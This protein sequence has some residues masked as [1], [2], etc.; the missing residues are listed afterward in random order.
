MK[1][2]TDGIRGP[3]ATVVTPAVAWALGRALAERLETGAT[4]AVARDSRSSG[5]ALE[6]AVYAGL[7]A[8]GIRVIRLG[9]L[10]TPGLSAL[11]RAQVHRDESGRLSGGWQAGV[12]ITASHNPPEDNGLKLFGELGTKPGRELLDQ[13]GAGIDRWLPAAPSS[14]P[15][16]PRLDSSFRWAVPYFHIFQRA[17]GASEAASGNFR[18]LEGLHIAVDCANGAFS[19]LAADFLELL[20][21]TPTALNTGPG[22]AINQDCGSLHPELLREHL[23]HS[24]ADYGIA[25]DGDGDR[26]ILLLSDGRIL[27][28]DDL[29]WILGQ[30][31]P[32]RSVVVGTVMTNAGLEVALA[33]R[34][35]SLERTPVGDS[36]VAEALSR[37][38][39]ISPEAPFLMT[40]L[41]GEPSGH[42]L[43]SPWIPCADGLLA[44]VRAIL[45]LSDGATL[46]WPRQPQLLRNLRFPHGIPS[47][48]EIQRRLA[49]L[50]AELEAQG[51]RIVVRPSGTEPLVR[52]MVEHPTEAEAALRRLC[53]ALQP[54]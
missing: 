2:G 41:G 25:L 19:A 51:T 5:P 11:L 18:P 53:D 21:A 20:G 1:F 16:L 22:T 24:N 27:D 8:G 46:D 35:L 9:V 47:T 15:P 50:T 36:Y 13:L 48:E 23:L 45:A 43:L 32:A 52:V 37:H 33:H 29:L 31:L 40:G 44:G 14:P 3:A 12:M 26:G 30:T 28:G 4:V 42:L 10:P 38:G 17:C 49:G 6:A 54:T 34:A 39:T 7:S